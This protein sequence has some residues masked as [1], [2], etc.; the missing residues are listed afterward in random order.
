[1]DYSEFDD[2]R[3][4]DDKDV[5]AILN[6][7]FTKS[8]IRN[9]VNLIFRN[10]N[11]FFRFFFYKKIKKW[12][13]V[14]LKDVKTVEDFQ[15]KVTKGTVE[16]ILKRG[17]AGFTYDGID[18]I[19]KGVG[20][21]FVSNHRDII[22]DAALFC[23]ILFKSDLPTCYN[24]FGDNLIVNPMVEAIL[25]INKCFIV[26]RNLPMREQFTSSKHLSKYI[27]ALLDNNESVWIAQR[28]GRSKDGSDITKPTILKMLNF[29]RRDKSVSFKTMMDQYKIVPIAISYEFDPCDQMKAKE[30]CAT[31]L[32]GSYVKKPYEDLKSMLSGI[33]GKKGRIHMAIGSVV[34]TEEGQNETDIALAI[35]KEIH[36]I[37][38]LWPIHYAAWDCY[39]QSKR[40]KEFYSDETISQLEKRME[41]LSEEEKP[42]LLLQY[43]N[44]VQN[45]IDEGVIQ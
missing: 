21:F 28:D 39:N 7:Y 14:A 6:Q 33:N 45:K 44:P 29:A 2:I 8:E 40:F 36:K 17:S 38:K 9:L 18:K 42:F 34:T 32:T 27:N 11:I 13:R 31:E 20:Y 4:Y 24:A 3:G 43:A 35:D 5:D 10:K 22:L 23:Y 37:Y 19:E 30:L 12:F 26:R 1:M 15:K 16:T 41:G 25:R